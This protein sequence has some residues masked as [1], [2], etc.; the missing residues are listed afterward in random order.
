MAQTKKKKEDRAGLIF[1]GIFFIGLALGFLYNNIVV[2]TFLGLGFGFIGKF[3]A[4]TLIN[5]RK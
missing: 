1:V 5:R 4:D 2:G 3:I